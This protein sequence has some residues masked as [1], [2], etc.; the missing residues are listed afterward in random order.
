VHIVVGLIFF[1]L[2][3]TCVAYLWAGGSLFEREPPLLA[4]GILLIVLGAGLAGRSRAAALIVRAGLGAGLVALVWIATSY[5][6]FRGLGATDDLLERAYLLGIALAAAG[7]VAFFLL[8]RRVP[9]ARVFRG[10]DLLSLAGV[11]AALTLGVVWLVDDD[12]RLRPCRLG[13][14]AACDIVATRLLESAERTP[15]A[16]PT[17]WEED[18]ARM[19][20]RHGCRGSEP[21]PCAVYRYA[22]GSVALRAGRFDAARQAFLRACDED[23]S[24]CARAAQETSL[25][26]TP[27]E[28]ARLER[29]R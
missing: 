23:R 25:P 19:L 6:R 20:D 22:I 27:E 24:W 9:Y 4:L 29:R 28:R 8:V 26:W 17:R 15:T 11:A 16:P 12:A 14:E 18:A 21:G 1:L 10:I 7:V 5:L 13:N 2:G 3:A